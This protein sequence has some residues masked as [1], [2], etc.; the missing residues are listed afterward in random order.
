MDEE[1]CSS[2]SEDIDCNFEGTPEYRPPVVQL[3]QADYDEL[4]DYLTSQNITPVQDISS[5][6]RKAKSKADCL[7]RNS[8][9]QC[10]DSNA[11]NL[12]LKEIEELDSFI[13]DYSQS[14]I[15]TFSQMKMNQNK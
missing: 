12:S 14:N 9:N 3:S 8:V 11:I 15:L 2:E 13:E 1:D 5:L 6:Q 7:K 10:D 4:D